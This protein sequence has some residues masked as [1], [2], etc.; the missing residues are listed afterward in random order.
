MLRAEFI[1]ARAESTSL[2]Q[3]IGGLSRN[4][5][6]TKN[7]KKPRSRGSSSGEVVRIAN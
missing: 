5:M 6:P 4:N 7:E 1:P 2:V 3:L